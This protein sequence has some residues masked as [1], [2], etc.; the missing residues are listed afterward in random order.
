MLDIFNDSLAKAKGRVTDPSFILIHDTVIK[1]HKLIRERYLTSASHVKPNNILIKILSGL[2]LSSNTDLNTLQYQVK[3]AG[4]KLANS[5]QVTSFNSYGKNFYNNFINGGS[6]SIVFVYDRFDES[7]WSELSPI[8]Y[9]YHTNT[10][11]NFVVGTNQDDNVFAFIKI[12][13][14][15]LAYQFIQWRKWRDLNQVEENVY[16]FL[17][18]Y[19]LFNSLKSYMDISLFNM[20]NYRVIGKPLRND[21]TVRLYPTPS[22]SDHLNKSNVKIINMLYGKGHTIGGTLYTTPSFFNDSALDLTHGLGG[23]Q[24][25][26]LEWF[27]LATR[28]PYIRY[29]LTINAGSGSKIDQKVVGQINRELKAFIGTRTLDKLPKDVSVW[30]IDEL[31][32]LLELTDALK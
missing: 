16:N 31:E 22:L 23:I 14:V 18:K 12:N 17:A 13:V 7:S 9:L 26:Q 5:L 6:E 11:V 25:R 19:P 4:R 24:T 2:G 28:I 8:E 30:L 1:N 10:N 21:D 3:D 29:A 32:E 27:T 15:M 20:H